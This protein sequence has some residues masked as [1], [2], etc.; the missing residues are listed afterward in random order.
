MLPVPTWGAIFVP[1]GDIPVSPFLTSRN[2]WSTLIRRHSVPVGGLIMFEAIMAFFEAN[3]IIL[4]GV[5]IFLVAAFM[6][7]L[8]LFAKPPS[9]LEDEP[10]FEEFASFMTTLD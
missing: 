1:Y 4:S 2:L 10:D 5:T 6:I 9:E 3:S 7:T 8:N